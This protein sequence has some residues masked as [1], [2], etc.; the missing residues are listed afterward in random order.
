MDTDTVFWFDVIDST[1]SEAYRNL[2]VAAHGTVWAA[3]FQTAGRGQKGNRWE[4]AAGEN[5]MFSILLR[6]LFIPADRQFL[7]SQAAALAVCDL[8]RT[9]QITASIKWPNDIYA[10][11]KKVA[12]VLIEH[13]VSGQ[14]LSASIVGIGLNLN[15]ER[16]DSDAPNPTSV[17]LETG[18]RHDPEAA[19]RELLC[20]LHHRYAALQQGEYVQTDGAYRE[21]LYRYGQ[22]AEYLHCVTGTPFT[23]KIAGVDVYGCLR[24][25]HRDGT[26]ETFS[27]KEVKYLF[28]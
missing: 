4:S 24:V 2:S 20:F 19:L 6:P 23:G 8:L 26:T 17:W 12:G 7:I 13:F 1:N 3:R 28:G 22:W 18:L 14:T 5:L 16:F 9:W 15:Q 27:F 25:E 10:G 11:D 21:K